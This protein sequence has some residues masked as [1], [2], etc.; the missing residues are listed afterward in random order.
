MTTQQIR[1]ARR[2]FTLIEIMVVVIVLGILA[3]VVIPNFVGQ[4]DEARVAKARSDITTLSTTIEQFRLHMR[5]YPYQDE[6]LDVL[7]TPPN[8]EDANNW[9]GPYL[10]KNVPKDPWGNPY[11][12]SE[13]AA[14]GIDPYGITSYGSDGAPGGEGIDQ[15]INSWEDYE[16]TQ[17]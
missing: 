1:R 4:T 14:N 5:R 17:N 3:A 11:I 10:T 12:Y 9:K 8:S 7:R 6:G 16:E 13:P 15:D 2:G